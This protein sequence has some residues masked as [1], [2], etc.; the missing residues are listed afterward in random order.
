MNMK[1]PT[2]PF[3]IFLLLLPLFSQAQE[4]IKI[5]QA[6]AERRLKI[7]VR[8]AGCYQG[9]CLRLA[10]KNPRRQDLNLVIPAGQVFV[11][12]D[13]SKQNLM[14]V[15]EEEIL[16][17]AGQSSRI[18]LQTMCIQSYNSS[19][20]KGERFSLGDL[21]SSYLLKIA[22]LISEHGYQNS[23]AQ[24]AVWSVA[25]A[26][27]IEYIY[28]D[29]SLMVRRL[30]EVVSEA[31]GAP[32]AKFR[33]TPRPHQITSIDA[34]MEVFLPFGKS[35][36][37]L[38]MGL[39]DE[40]GNLI[41]S[42]FQGREYEAGF[43][44]WKVGANHCLG[45]E[46]SVYLRLFRGQEMIQ[47]QELSP[48]DS[49]LDLQYLDAEATLIYE[50]PHETSAHVGVYDR[51]GRLYLLLEEDKNLK[52]GHHRSRYI[53][54]IPVLPGQEYRVQVRKGETLIAEAPLEVESPSR[55]IYPKE[56]ENGRFVIELS[57]AVDEVRLAIY[58]EDGRIKRVMY[59]IHHLNPGRKTF[60]YMFEH[61]DGPQA[62]FYARLTDASGDILWE[63]ELR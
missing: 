54:K 58:E 23:T 19:P 41:R 44:Q 52:E 61:R 39:Y 27:P 32:L 37:D 25:N 55:P 36:Q 17:K 49:I 1:I 46:A 2:P 11:S 40:E 57:Q 50:I 59:D 8:G 20:G 34:S 47:E 18:S 62:R 26:D 63:R 38:R 48:S 16:V 10:L 7:A 21:A 5:D 9:N 42:Y 33:L 29:D 4:V 51:E 56:R 28:G 35:H 60:S 22:E 45:D 24:S 14:V 12:H 13:S 43:Y 30:A 3:L 53:A 6:L 31:T 15:E